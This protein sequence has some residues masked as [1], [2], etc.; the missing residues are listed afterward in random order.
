M[1]LQTSMGNTEIVTQ[2]IYIKCCLFVI[3]VTIIFTWRHC[4]THFMYV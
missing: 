2:K 1:A 3:K 4:I